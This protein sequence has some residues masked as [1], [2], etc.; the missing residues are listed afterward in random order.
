MAVLAYL[1]LAVA[2]FVVGVIGSFG[3]A[4]T[5]GLGP[6]P[7]P[8]GLVGMLAATGA[9]FYAGARLDPRP[10][11]VGLPALAWLIGVFPF[12]I[13]RPE[14]DIVLSGDLRSYAYLVLGALLALVAAVVA[15]SRDAAPRPVSADLGGLSAPLNGRDDH[16][17]IEPGR[18]T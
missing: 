1:V 6:V 15:S 12:T 13:R 16:K 2:G 8:V 9:V 3:Q 18:A 7:L 5:V 11:G 14:G 4:V 17:T 10:I